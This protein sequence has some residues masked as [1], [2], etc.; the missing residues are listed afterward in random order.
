MNEKLFTTE[1]I[2]TATNKSL[3]MVWKILREHS[4]LDHPANVVGRT[5][6]YDEKTYNDIVAA[7]REMYSYDMPEPGRKVFYRH[8]LREMFTLSR[9]GLL[10]HLRRLNIEPDGFNKVAKT[11]GPEAWYYFET[12]QPLFDYMVEKGKIP[13]ELMQAS[14]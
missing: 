1:D 6:M 8:Q 4:E 3:H 2:A 9:A 10:H 12:L 13:A 5:R 11:G 14:A 7:I